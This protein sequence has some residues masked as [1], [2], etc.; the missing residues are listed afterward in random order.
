MSLYKHILR[1]HM[2]FPIFNGPGGLICLYTIYCT[3]SLTFIEHQPAAAHSIPIIYLLFLSFSKGNGKYADGLDSVPLFLQ[4]MV[5]NASIHVYATFVQAY[6]IDMLN[7]FGCIEMNFAI[8]LFSLL[9]TQYIHM[10]G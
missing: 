8:K 7:C 1:M 2:L 5:D 4:N 10:Q 6:P 3:A 9:S